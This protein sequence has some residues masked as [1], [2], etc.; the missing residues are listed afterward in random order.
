M[1][2]KFLAL[3]TLPL[4]AVSCNKN[5]NA[6]NYSDFIL[7]IGQTG[8]PVGTYSRQILSRN[9]ISESH[10]FESGHL[11][12]GTDVADVATKVKQSMVGAGIVYKTDAFTHGLNSIDAATSAMCDEVIYPVAVISSSSKKVA[13]SSFKSYLRTQAAFTIF[14]SVGFVGLNPISEEE[15]QVSEAVELN[16]FA[17]RSLQAT[18]NSVI[19]AYNQVHSNVTIVPNYAG[20]GALATQIKEGADCD[21]FISADEVTMDGLAGY[22]DT[23]SR[24]DLLQNQVVLTVPQGNPYQLTGFAQLIQIL[25]GF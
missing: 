5:G 18:L 25:K 3:L 20:S 17:A 11:T 1:K 22:Y 8:V 6:V 14:E 9:E 16:V 2:K 24:V 15:P 23:D 7:A 4:I 13:A 19:A 21:L 12:Y 10:L